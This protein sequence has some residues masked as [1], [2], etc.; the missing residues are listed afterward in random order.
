MRVLLHSLEGAWLQHV[1]HQ[2]QQRGKHK[3]KKDAKQ[4][5]DKD[6]AALETASCIFGDRG[7]YVR[8]ELELAEQTGVN[9]HCMQAI[10]TTVL[11]TAY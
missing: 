9:E 2:Q 5:L 6:H 1:H 10:C 4:N 8:H 7:G 11:W 3:K